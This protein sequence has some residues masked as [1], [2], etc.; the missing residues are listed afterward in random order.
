MP[1]LDDLVI[2]IEQWIISIGIINV[3]ISHESTNLR[4][5]S[6]GCGCGCCFF[7]F[8]VCIAYSSKRLFT[9][10]DINFLCFTRIWM[11]AHLTFDC[12]IWYDTTF[13]SPLVLSK[14]CVHYMFHV[15]WFTTV[16][17]QSTWIW[18]DALPTFAQRKLWHMYF[19]EIGFWWVCVFV[20]F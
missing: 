11:S 5:Y 17:L 7:F 15:A 1:H 6:C 9:I 4:S 19:F 3:I 12:Y 14:S 13:N 16:I 20:G 2:P 18:M 10:D 8:L